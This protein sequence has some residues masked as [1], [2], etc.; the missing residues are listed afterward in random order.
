MLSMPKREFAALDDPRFAQCHASTLL[1]LPGGDFLAAWFGGTEEGAG[2]VGIWLGRRTSDGWTQPRQVAAEPELP[3]WN[4][5]L[6]ATGPDEIALFYKVGTQIPAWRTRVIR[7]ADGGETWSPPSE[8]VPGDSG[9]RGPVKN[10]PIR[11]HDGTI[12]APASLE[13]DRWDAF[14]DLSTDQGATWTASE[15]V[16]M[17]LPTPAGRRGLI[18]PA[19]WEPAPGTLRMLARSTEGWVYTSTSTDGGASWE[20]ARPTT[21]PNNN[22]GIDATP[23]AGGAHVV[24][25]Y[26]PVSANWGARTPLVL[27][28]STDA[29]GETWTPGPVIDDVDDQPDAR[30]GRAELSYPAVVPYADGIAMTYTWQRR[31][32]AFAIVPGAELIGDEG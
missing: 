22:S 3:H 4:P 5:V 20:P 10:K 24:C 29:Y 17:D 19:L 25:A 2:D 21:L 12:A 15:L 28:V 13:G 32:I 18:Q 23:I 30:T 27:A 6:F 31:G 26:N 8:L 16:P 1:P 11:L 9:G 14:A 7:S